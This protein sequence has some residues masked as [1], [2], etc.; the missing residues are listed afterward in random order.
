MLFPVAYYQRNKIL[1]SFFD[2][3]VGSVLLYAFDAVFAGSERFITFR[4]SDDLAVSGAKAETEFAV[5]TLV[6]FEF[7]I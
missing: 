4:G 3:G 5:F 6:N 2:F 7:G 1:F